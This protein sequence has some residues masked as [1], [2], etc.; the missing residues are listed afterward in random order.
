MSKFVYFIKSLKS[1]V[2]YVGISENPTIRL[3]EHNAGKSTFTK[4]HI[5]WV[6]IYQEGPFETDIARQREKFLKRSSNK[7]KILKN[8]E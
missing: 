5:P 3:K 8:L 6:L 4:G 1:G 2:V 7:Q